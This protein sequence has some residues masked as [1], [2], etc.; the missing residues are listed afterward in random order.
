MAACR[1]FS[2]GFAA[3]AALAWAG[4]PA[5]AATVPSGLDFLGARLGMTLQDWKAVPTP[6]GAGP[7][8]VAICTDQDK[9]VRIPGYPLSAEDVRSGTV[10]CAYK[11]RF[12]QDVLRHSVDIDPNFRAHDLAFVFRRGHLDEIRFTAAEEAY[13]DLRQTL[14]LRGEAAGPR[15]LGRGLRHIRTWR[16]PGARVTI[17][18]GPNPS[19]LTVTLARR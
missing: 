17:G 1:S 9:T 14:G 19:E 12:G 11:A 2:A 6:R 15:D 4:P 3:L 13:G 5:L 8:A 10:V 18:P 7:D 16:A